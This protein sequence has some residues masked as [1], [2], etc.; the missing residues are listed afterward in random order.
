ME[1]CVDE[2]SRI[3]KGRYINPITC[4]TILHLIYMHSIKQIQT[5]HIPCINF[6][7]YMNI[8]DMKLI[9]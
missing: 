5:T 6:I 4:E 9:S 3:T 8:I 2:D 7:Q 1:L